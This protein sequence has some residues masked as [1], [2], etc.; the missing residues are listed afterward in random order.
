MKT[1]FYSLGYV[2]RY[3]GS[4]LSDDLCPIEEFRDG[5]YQKGDRLWFSREDSGNVSIAGF[6]S[7]GLLTTR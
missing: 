2:C 6:L 4:D 7:R 5:F 1:L 3:L